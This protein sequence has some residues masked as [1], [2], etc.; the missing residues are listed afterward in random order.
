MDNL[1]LGRC[2]FYIFVYIWPSLSEAA[3]FAFLRKFWA[4]E[5]EMW[6][7]PCRSRD[8]NALEIA[9]LDL[10]VRAW[11]TRYVSCT[12]NSARFQ[13]TVD[14]RRT[15]RTLNSES[16]R[17]GSNLSITRFGVLVHGVRLPRSFN[18]ILGIV[19][20]FRW[21]VLVADGFDDECAWPL[22]LPIR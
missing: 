17:V 14:R 20:F 21:F 2:S 16:L 7:N 12:G 11:S 1:S 8:T 10:P 13:P 9:S 5:R 6:I 19:R 22:C 4:F 3:F 15:M 18:L